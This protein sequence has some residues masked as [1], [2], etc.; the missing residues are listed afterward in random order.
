M[1]RAAQHRGHPSE[2][3]IEYR[4][5]KIVKVPAVPLNSHPARLLRQL[6]DSVPDVVPVVSVVQHERQHL[7]DTLHELATTTRDLAHALYNDNQYED[8]SPSGTSSTRTPPSQE[9]EVG[10]PSQEEEDA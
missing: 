10:S 4:L 1:R 9:D 5:S 8:T 7:A 2:G 3:L 6:F